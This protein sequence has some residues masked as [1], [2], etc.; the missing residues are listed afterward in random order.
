MAQIRTFNTNS[1][2]NA[3]HFIPNTTVGLN[4]GSQADETHLFLGTLHRYKTKSTKTKASINEQ[5]TFVKTR[6][7]KGQVCSNRNKITQHRE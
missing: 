2:P 5:R 6:S 1:T 7:S 4:Y 3:L